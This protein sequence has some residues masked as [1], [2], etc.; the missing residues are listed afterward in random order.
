MV[1]PKPCEERFEV[2]EFSEDMANPLPKRE[3]GRL[4][5]RKLGGAQTCGELANDSPIIS[6][7]LSRGI[8]HSPV[9]GFDRREPTP[10]TGHRGDDLSVL[11]VDRC[12]KSTHLMTPLEQSPQLMTD[13]FLERSGW[14]ERNI[15][16]EVF[17]RTGEL[18]DLVAEHI[19][20]T[21]VGH[22]GTWH[23]SLIYASE[24]TLAMLPIEAINHN[25]SEVLTEE[26]L[27]ALLEKKEPEDIIAYCGYE[28]SGPVH[29]GHLVTI[30]KLKELSRSGIKVKVLFADYH[31]F[32]NRKGDWAFIH[33]QAQ[34][35]E[36]TFRA[37]GLEAEFVLGSTFQRS[38]EY[39]DDVL[40]LALKT[41][42]KRGLRSMEMVARD[43]DHAK[44]SQVIYPLMQTADIKWLNIDI[45]V[46][47]MEQRKIHALAREI[48]SEISD[49]P[50]V[51]IHTPLITSLVGEGKM[52][53]SVPDSNVSFEDSEEEIMR[54]ISKAHC[55]AKVLEGNPIIEIARLIIFPYAGSITIERPEKFGGELVFGSPEELE[56]AFAG[57]ALHPK[58]LKDAVASYIVRILKG[59]MDGS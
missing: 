13:I 37:A 15:T 56:T 3:R 9:S 28:T 26:D 21:M 43:F 8:E 54:K 42:M 27:A 41:S 11:C 14:F 36:S 33:K 50:F 19:I 57:G 29:L 4:F 23:D 30:M 31:T 51:A 40:A 34:L 58:D 49:R 59:G 39:F 35:W 5:E 17:D 38:M 47:G 44:V 24:Q 48:F 10:L 22:S 7:D 6:V 1:F 45:A 18:G 20:A 2:S 52:S 53:S 12:D 25:T 32:L 55:P 16:S 46:G